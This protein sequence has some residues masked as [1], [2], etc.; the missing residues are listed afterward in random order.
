MGPLRNWEIVLFALH[1]EGGTSKGVHTEDVALR[2]FELAPDAFSWLKHRQ[3]ADK[4][5]VRKDLIRLR[6]GQYGEVFVEG[7][8]GKAKAIGAGKT[9][10]G[11]ELTSAGADWIR[12]NEKRI[13]DSLGDRTV[14]M[15]RQELL[16]SLKRLRDSRLFQDF[17]KG[18]ASFS[19]GVGPLAELFRCRADA[20]EA[21]WDKR[22][23]TF[24]KQARAADNADLCEFLDA[25]ESA[26]KTWLA[27]DKA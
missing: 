20:D 27:S 8:A 12:T 24:R 26:W 25:C 15:D 18:R 9:A 22:F 17:A 7:R 3:Y 23:S 16:R 1:I 2:C 6:M 10:D 21:V 13:R 14:R 11:W 5:V 4:E 19:P